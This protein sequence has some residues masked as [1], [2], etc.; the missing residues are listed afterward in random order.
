[1]K[2]AIRVILDILIFIS[3]LN[4]WWPVAAVLVIIGAW[5][6][7]YFVE[8]IIAGVAYD[9]LFGMSHGMG[10]EGYIGT[11]GAVAIFI[12]VRLLKRLVR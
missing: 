7:G 3:I 5:S 4:A 8:L 11:I 1:M 9:S 10:W 2:T 6:F 12:L